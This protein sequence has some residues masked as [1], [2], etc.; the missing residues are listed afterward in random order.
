MCGQLHI[1]NCLCTS[2]ISLIT[3]SLQM[4][5]QSPCQRD[6]GL[7]APRAHCTQTVEEDA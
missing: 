6:L 7:K 5:R 2:V 3:P 1:S 4:S